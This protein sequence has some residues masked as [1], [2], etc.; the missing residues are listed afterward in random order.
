M[1][2]LI[3][4]IPGAKNGNGG[5]YIAL[6]GKLAELFYLPKRKAYFPTP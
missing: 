6:S 2:T 5:V 4:L 1:D 3:K